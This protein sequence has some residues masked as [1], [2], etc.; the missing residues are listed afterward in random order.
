MKYNVHL[1]ENLTLSRGLHQND[2]NLCK[3]S[4]VPI[5]YSCLCFILHS[6]VFSEVELWVGF[7]VCLFLC[8]FVLLLLLLSFFIIIIILNK[9]LTPTF[10]FQQSFHKKKTFDISC[11]VEGID[12]LLKAHTGFL[13]EGFQIKALWREANGEKKKKKGAREIRKEDQKIATVT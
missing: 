8:L 6:P 4:V 5:C 9:F 12:F 7:F 10:S 2:L 11:L 13:D 1:L 3:P